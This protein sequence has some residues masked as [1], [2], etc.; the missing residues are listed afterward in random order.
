MIVLL[1]GAGTLTAALGDVPDT[2]IIATVVV[3]NTL[4]G[5][6]QEVRAER[7]ITALHALTAPVAS[8]TR[9]GA[10]R[11]IPAEEVVP[12]DIL[13]LTAGDL[14]AADAEVL[15]AYRLQLDRSAMTGES[16]PVDVGDQDEVAAGTLVTS[17]RAVTRVT[18]TGADSGLGKLALLIA[19]A[20]ERPTPLQRR[21]TQ[22]SRTLVTV[23]G[24]LTVVIA[25]IGLSQGR[26]VTDMAILGVS[27]AVAAVPESLPAVVA[28]AL[29]M[30]AYRMARRDAVVRK[31]PAVE[32]LGS[33][34]VIA[35]DKT[36]T[37]TEGRMVAE[38]VW[39]PDGQYDVQGRGYRPEG[40]ITPTADTAD[41]DG[42]R[43]S[44]DRLLR[45]GALCNDS[46][47]LVDDGEWAVEGDPLEGA[48][49]VLAAKGGQPPE[50]LAEAWPRV[51]EEPFDHA[52]RR[53]ITR[54]EGPGGVGL[55]VC[56]GAPEAV[57]AMVAGGESAVAARQAADDMADSGYRVIAVA[58]REVPASSVRGGAPSEVPPALDIVGLVGIDDP[59]RELAGD[60][61][62]RCQRAGI[63]LVLV[64]GDHPG[65]ARA[66]AERT[67][68]L[69]A[70]EDADAEPTVHARVQP[71][72]KVEIVRALQDRGDVVA[73]LGDGVNDAPALRRADIGVAAGRGGT[74][75]ARQAADL[76]LMDDNLATVV[77]AVEEGRRIFANIRSF[78]VY[79]VS[80]G[81]AEVG[82]M[83]LGPMLGIGQPLL[84]AQILWINLLTHGLTGVAF[85]AE[86]AD[87]AEMAKPPRPP[88][89]PIVTRQ[90]TGRLAVAAACLVVVSLGAGLLLADGTAV[91]QRTSIFLTLGLG[92]LGVA[93]ALRARTRTAR[94][95]RSLDIAVG[96]AAALMLLATVIPVLHELLGTVRLTGTWL[97]IALP[98]AL[99]PGAVIAILRARERGR[100]LSRRDLPHQRHG[101]PGAG[102]G[103]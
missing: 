99:A 79:A 71:A 60:V 95:V 87:P 77:H 38:R 36:G 10:S 72:D 81:M 85:G 64:T 21:L 83:L 8:V 98:L 17:G 18:R 90:L 31:L 52:T 45:D 54:H 29:A 3:L 20:P 37:L 61:V 59:P 76:V 13:R 42:T 84:P 23:V 100:V 44:L 80:G 73:M 70:D 69:P 92:Q 68:I 66:I 88:G 11:Q 91:E 6:V 41:T 103:G 43:R 51:T 7:A 9:D 39:T 65:T 22:L 49:L 5:V 28:L 93:L 57:L 50:S 62:A 63:R 67:G 14:V 2:I 4:I 24:M 56:K 53:M 48:L 30:G 19:T 96:G 33:V 26:S 101:V 35:T 102:R 12:G 74:E 40:A 15:A 94:R 32:T 27:L 34:S 75:V 25:G 47:L 46:R 97:T 58:D 16:M 89:E 1:L 86:P 78:L 82:V 55:V